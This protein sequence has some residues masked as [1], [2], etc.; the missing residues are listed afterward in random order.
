VATC[1]DA[2]GSRLVSFFDETG[3]VLLGGKSADELALSRE[4]QPAAFDRYLIDHSFKSYTMKGR[5]KNEMFQDEAKLKISCTQLTPLDYV[6][7]G[8][9]L[10]QDIA[11][12]RSF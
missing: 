2:S 7:T 8:R 4:Q 5:V 6:A 10:L 9:A 1:N 11:A 12:L 3:T